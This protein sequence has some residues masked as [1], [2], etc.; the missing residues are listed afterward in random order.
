MPNTAQTR[1]MSQNRIINC[2]GP[3]SQL[4]MV[5]DRRHA[6]YPFALG[7][8]EIDHLD[9][10][11]QR[12]QDK[13]SPI[14][15]RNNVVRVK[16]APAAG[17]HAQAQSTVSPINTW[18]AVEPGKPQAGSV[19]AKED[20]HIRAAAQPCQDGKGQGSCGSGSRRVAVRPSVYLRHYWWPP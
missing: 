10:Y 16:I 1:L 9:D 8:P 18:D 17:R 13:Q 3:S 2:F 5:M 20:G 6:K 7:Y 15:G 11:R 19:T 14:I 4:K 12:L